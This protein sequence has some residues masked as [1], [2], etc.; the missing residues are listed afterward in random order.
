MQMSYPSQESIPGWVHPMNHWFFPTSDY[1]LSCFAF[2]PELFPFYPGHSGRGG[3][4]PGC[5]HQIDLGFKMGRQTISMWS[6]MHP[7]APDELFILISLIMKM[8]SEPQHMCFLL[9]LPPQD[10]NIVL[11]GESREGAQETVLSL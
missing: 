2:P 6:A 10:D 3:W 11:I 8:S 9:S 1:S 5:T 4:V 7:Q